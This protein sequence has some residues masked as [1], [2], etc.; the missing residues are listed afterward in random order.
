MSVLTKSFFCAFSNL[1]SPASAYFALSLFIWMILN[2]FATTLITYTI[3]LMVAPAS[4]LVLH[5]L[6]QMMGKCSVV[7]YGLSFV[8]IFFN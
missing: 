7:P 1:A 4:D 2:L 8:S 5:S 6:F 3:E